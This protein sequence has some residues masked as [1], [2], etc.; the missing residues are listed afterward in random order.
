MSAL[1]FGTQIGGVRAHL[2]TKFGWITVKNHKVICTENNPN[3]LSRPQ[4]KP[5]LENWCRGGLT[6]EPQTFCG[7][8]EIELKIMKI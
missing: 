2:G 7:L 5:R 4:G 3:M 6:I 8:K 1:K